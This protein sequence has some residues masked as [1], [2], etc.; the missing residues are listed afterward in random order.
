MI[1]SYLLTNF[2]TRPDFIAYNYRHAHNISRR[3]CRILGGL[4]V[5]YTIKSAE[6]YEQAKKDFELIIFD[7]FILK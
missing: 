3:V 5:A 7:S 6:A 1:M 2:V 4:A